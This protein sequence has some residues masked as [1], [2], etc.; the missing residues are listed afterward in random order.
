MKPRRVFPVPITLLT[1]VMPALAVTSPAPTF[2]TLKPPVP[3]CL[4][5]GHERAGEEV[6][7]VGKGDLGGGEK[8]VAN[9]RVNTASHRL[10]VASP[11]PTFRP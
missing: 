10:T 9:L 7:R 5:H 11:F 3:E 1:L 4:R 6:H 8:D 2:V